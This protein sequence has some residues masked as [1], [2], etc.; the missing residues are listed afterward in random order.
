VTLAMA[1][2]AAA[3]MPAPAARAAETGSISGTVTAAG[4]TEVPLEGVQV[5][6]FAEQVLKCDDTGGEGAEPGEYSIPNL[7][8]RSYLVGFYPSQGS[9]YVA[10]F[11]KEAAGP[12]EAD[13][14][15]VGEGQQVIGIDAK[16]IESGTIEGTVTDAANGAPV[17]GARVCAYSYCAETDAFGTYA[18]SGLPPD[19]YILRFT[20]DGYVTE[21]YKDKYRE[22]EADLLPVDAAQIVTVDE[23]VG[24][25]PAAQEEAPPAPFEP[26]ALLP[27][28][29]TTTSTPPRRKRCKRGFRRKKVRGH[30]RCV[31]KHRKRR[32]ATR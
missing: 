8:P 29:S 21:F 6:A 2:L 11:Y 13:P 14:V 30:Y 19:Q 7:P 27:T 24:K 18:I 32:Q 1:A 9:G 16:L 23:S 12:A 3:L 31:K 25:P 15:S 10:Q 26:P 17:A 5:C 4:G 20:A 28:G 22:A